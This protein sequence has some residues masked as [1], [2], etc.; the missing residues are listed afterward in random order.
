MCGPTASGKSAIAL[1]IA[2][3]IGAVII[4]A[5]SQQ[6]YRDLQV[7]SARPTRQEMQEVQHYLYGVLDSDEICNA[8]MYLDL[9]R[10]VLEAIPEDQ[11]V[12]FVGGTGMYINALFKGISPIPEIP[13]NVRNKVRKMEMEEVKTWLK[14]P[15][16]AGMDGNLQRMKRALEVQMAT[17]KSLKDWHS[18]PYDHEFKREDFLVFCLDMPRDTLYEKIDGRFAWMIENGGI[19]EVEDLMKLGLDENFPVMKAIGVPEITRFINDE[20]SLAEA[21]EKAQTNVRNYAK[22]QMTW[23]RNQLENEIK[24][25]NFDDDLILEEIKKHEII[26]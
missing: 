6:V 18:E 16:D 13:S 21:I 5:D 4:N 26:Q 10:I 15:L 19:A 3:Q 9:V 2:Q 11:P 1:R 12:I 20:I 25:T 8:G 17:G 24:I 14:E 7:I 22:R 23:F